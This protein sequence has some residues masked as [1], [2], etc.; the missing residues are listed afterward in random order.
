[1]TKRQLQFGEVLRAKRLGKKFSLRR[2]AELV[3]VSPTYL[4][5]VEQANVDPP[6]AERVQKMAELLEENPDELIALAGRVA[7]DLP[8]IIRAKTE[9]PDLLRA[10]RGLSAEQLRKLRESAEEMK[11]DKSKKEK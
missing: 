9:V 1:M 5:Q 2:F 6:T 7:D 8:A 4:S 10:V 11:R 3:G